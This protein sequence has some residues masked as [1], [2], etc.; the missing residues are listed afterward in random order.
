MHIPVKHS[1]LTAS[2]NCK[3][4]S[5]LIEHWTACG[6]TINKT[7]KLETPGHRNND[8]CSNGHTWN[9][10]CLNSDLRDTRWLYSARSPMLEW[11]LSHSLSCWRMEKGLGSHQMQPAQRKCELHSIS[12]HVSLIYISGVIM[13]LRWVMVPLKQ[14]FFP[15]VWTPAELTW[16]SGQLQELQS[17]YAA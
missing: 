1:S 12:K 4:S 10:S 16:K 13:Q 15:R 2:V 14:V 9:G 11:T 3:W 8:R 17:C 5:V 7:E 6:D